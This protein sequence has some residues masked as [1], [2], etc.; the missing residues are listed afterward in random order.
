[1]MGVIAE[2]ASLGLVVSVEYFEITIAA[3]ST[4]NTATLPSA[5]TNFTTLHF[6]GYTGS[7]TGAFDASEDHP[8]IVET[9]GTTI[10]AERHSSSA[11]TVTVYGCRVLWNSE[12]IESIQKVSVV[13][14][15]VTS[16]TQA[17]TSVDRDNSA[18]FYN[19]F[20]NAYAGTSVSNSFISIGFSA[21]D[22]V[23]GYAG[24]TAVDGEVFASIIEFKPG[25]L[26]VA[27]IEVAITI[28]VTTESQ[29]VTPSASVGNSL[30]AFGGFSTTANASGWQY[31]PYIELAS[32]GSSVDATRDANTTNDP[33]IRG[34]L[35]QFNSQ[36]IA[37]NNRSV[38]VISSG[39]SSNT[40]TVSVKKSKTLTEF[41]GVTTN[42][43]LFDPEIIGGVTQTDDTTITLSRNGSPAID[44]TI[45]YD[46]V[47]FA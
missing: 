40:D 9:N 28:A 10:T 14:S 36:Y 16:A 1:M 34:T 22:E 45:S 42:T 20:T 29:T 32:D 27:A 31:Y 25:V 18:I 11:E 24:G 2:G 3:S 44:A 23:T 13:V 6:G 43:G 8:K 5:N 12:F 7:S 46:S 26:S 39:N 33:T 35:L 4:S 15:G 41:L 38:T 47:E 37:S 30:L 21:D 17:I 19:G